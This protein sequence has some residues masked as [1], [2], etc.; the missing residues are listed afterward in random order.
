MQYSPS[1]KSSSLFEIR[2]HWVSHILIRSVSH[3]AM[4]KFR[5]LILRF[6]GEITSTILRA[7]WSIDL[8]PWSVRPTQFLYILQLRVSRWDREQIFDKAEV[9]R[10]PSSLLFTLFEFC[11]RYTNNYST[12]PL[13]GRYILSLFLLS[14][15][16]NHHC[17]MASLHY[18]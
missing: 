18:F 10:V 3:C 15:L 11:Y 2:N 13:L 4:S 9:Y 7:C 17:N 5:N 14:S 16:S 1:F 6:M 8:I 12:F